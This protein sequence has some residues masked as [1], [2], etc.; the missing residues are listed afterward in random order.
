MG[1]VGKV[2][3]V[4]GVVLVGVGLVLVL[5][6]KVPWLGRLPGD[7]AVERKHFT[8]YFPVAS[9]LLLSVVVT[10]MVWLLRRPR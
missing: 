3:I 1:E 10:L 9:C 4:V 2:C 6:G 5:G 7:V 8:L